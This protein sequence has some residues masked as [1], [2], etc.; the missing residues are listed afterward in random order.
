MEATLTGTPGALVDGR[1]SVTKADM[2]DQPRLSARGL[3]TVVW[4]D[5]NRQI[6]YMRSLVRNVS[7]GGALI[8]S[9]HPLPVGACVRIRATNLYFL[10]GCGRVRHCR[11]RGLAYLIGVK[12]DSEIAARF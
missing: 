12:F 9:Y 6:R 2:R 11:R 1:G 3:L 10:A 8:L 5:E 7:G 4:R